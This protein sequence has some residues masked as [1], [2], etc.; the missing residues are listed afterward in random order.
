MSA[1][2]LVGSVIMGDQKVSLAVQYLIRCQVDISSL[3]SR[4][5]EQDAPLVQ[6]VIRFWEEQ[7]RDYAAPG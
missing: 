1:D 6:L 2:R 3:R 7:E 5:L 4:L